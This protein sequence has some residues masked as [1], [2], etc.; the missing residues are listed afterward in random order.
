[1]AKYLIY[2]SNNTKILTT[3]I[4]KDIN[5]YINRFLKQAE[6]IYNTKLKVIKIEKI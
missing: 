5:I 4:D 2:F 6:N 3:I 1:M